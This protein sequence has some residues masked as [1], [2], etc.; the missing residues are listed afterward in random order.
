M[1]LRNSIGMIVLLLVTAIACSTS[2]RMYKSAT[3]IYNDSLAY[4]HWIGD[5]ASDSLYLDSTPHRSDEE[6]PVHYSPDFAQYKLSLRQE[7][8][9]FSLDKS[10]NVAADLKNFSYLCKTQII[11]DTIYLTTLKS[12]DEY[13][14]IEIFK[15]IKKPV[16]KIFRKDSKI[17]ATPIN[18]GKRIKNFLNVYYE[19]YPDTLELHAVK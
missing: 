19:D 10:G 14:D 18:Y 13:L 8:T 16:L 12:L 7:S 3:Y 4:S 17:L 11:K 6:S 15:P 9:I 1:T 5:Y 2:T